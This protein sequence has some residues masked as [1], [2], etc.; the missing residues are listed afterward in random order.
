MSHDPPDGWKRYT[1][2]EGFGA[3]RQPCNPETPQLLRGFLELSSSVWESLFFC[4]RSAV[5]MWKQGSNVRG[6]IS[7]C[8]LWLKLFKPQLEVF[9]LLKQFPDDV[10]AGDLAFI[11]PLKY[12]APQLSTH[13]RE[14]YGSL[15]Q[16]VGGAVGAVGV[17]KNYIHTVFIYH[18]NEDYDE[19][20]RISIYIYHHIIYWYDIYVY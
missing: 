6:E 12:Q 5:Q 18:F 17:C 2:G 10:S 14:I 16:R 11:L 1:G 7:I 3:S 19:T 13:Q 4:E 15:R 9:P 8:F 20:W